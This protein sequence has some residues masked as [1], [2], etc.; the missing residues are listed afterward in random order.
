MRIEESFAVG[1]EPERVFDY[2]TDP[3]RLRD[4]QTTKTAVEQL[5]PGPP[6][7]GTRI[8]EVTK[9]PGGREFEQVSEFTEFDRPRRVTVHVVEGPH[10]MDGTWTFS[11]TAT[12]TEVHFVAKGEL[13]GLL[14]RFGP[15]ARILIG[16][17]FAGYHRR[18]KRNLE[19]S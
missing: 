3:D 12:G 8:R 2:L 5:T 10:P 7:P 16:R 19:A 6:G 1:R 17:Q 4:W 11:P 15:I 13:T 14:G 9:P 18:L